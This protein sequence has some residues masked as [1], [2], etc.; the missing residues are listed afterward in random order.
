MTIRSVLIILAA[1][2]LA[3]PAA[4][5]AHL[6]LYHAGIDR[7]AGETREDDGHVLSESGNPL[8]GQSNRIVRAGTPGDGGL[9]LDARVTTRFP[10]IGHATPQLY[11]DSYLREAVGRDDMIFPG[12]TA[13]MAWYGFWRDIDGDGAIDDVH[14]ASCGATVCGDDEFAWRGL[15]RDEVLNV[16]HYS[17]PEQFAF[18]YSEGNRS[19]F[20]MRVLEDSTALSQPEQS[21]TVQRG[22][23][24]DGPLIMTVQTVTIADAKRAA[25]SVL[26]YDF[27]DP[28]ALIDVDRYES[29]NADVEA[30]YI[31][32][33]N[34][35]ENPVRQIYGSP[36]TAAELLAGVPTVGLPDTSATSDYSS[37]RY[38]KEPDHMDDDSE[39]RMLFDG[40]ADVYGRGNSYAGYADGFHL[41]ADNVVRGRRCLGVYAEVP[42]STAATTVYGFCPTFEASGG[43]A[44]TE[45]R[46]G[47]LMNF[48]ARMFLWHDTNGDTHIGTVCDRDSAS[49]D[50]EGNTCAPSTQPGWPHQSSTREAIASCA[51]T[52]GRD[53]T[54]TVSPVGGN[55]PN[56]VVARD[57]AETT[58]I[59]FEDVGHWETRSDDS[60][61]TL[62]WMSTCGNTGLWS[63]DALFFPS[64]VTDVSVRV[65][66]SFSID[67]YRDDALGIVV[68]HE[69]VRD[70]DVIPGSL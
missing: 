38:A 34:E 22:Y 41:Y 32:A 31:S 64:G 43:F 39:G 29:M 47:A 15:A 49:F 7:A 17:V 25:G 16:V 4:S 2:A 14:D 18:F 37:P 48:E 10:G 9:F 42:T 53:T 24:F 46:A 35:L 65:D 3:A 40:V 6:T 63:R 33:Y 20:S 12:D 51:F 21:W 59:A 30:L 52:T 36:A 60:P 13:V 27:D 50:A 1:F 28:N 44:E 56:V 58:R 69:S 26:A 54:F 8:D 55:W 68:E 62:R 57:W 61:I 67:G 11:G 45:Q 70:V 66:A 23:A 19:R 5:A